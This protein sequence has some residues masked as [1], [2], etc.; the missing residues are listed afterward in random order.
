M[1]SV[2]A[3]VQAVYLVPTSRPPADPI[4]VV[5]EYASRLLVAS[6]PLL[7]GEM[8]DRS[9]LRVRVDPAESTRLPPPGVLESFGVSADEAAAVEAASHVVTVRAL[10]RPSWP[11]ANEWVARV[12]A[13][14]I[15][16]HVGCHVIDARLPMLVSPTVAAEALPDQR[17]LFAASRWLLVSQQARTDG[18]WCYTIGLSRFGLPELQTPAV[19]PQLARA[20]TEMLTGLANALVKWWVRLVNVADPPPFVDLP[21]MFSFTNWDMAEAYRSPRPAERKSVSVRLLL[22]PGQ[23]NNTDT[24][25]TVSPP[26]DYGAPAG[27][28]LAEVCA[29]LLGVTKRSAFRPVIQSNQMA[30]AIE[31]A[32]ATLPSARQRF[33]NGELR[34]GTQLVVKSRVIT[35]GTDEYLWAFVTSW[36][37]PSVIRATSSANSPGD[38]AIKVG[39]PLTIPVDDVVD[40]GAWRDGHGIIE[41]GWTNAAS[42]E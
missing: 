30:E 17:C 19:P 3:R 34:Q 21:S 40:W 39:V 8:I 25:L 35:S 38:P 31:T 2:P 11:P 15:G 41:G 33:L 28:F 7:V 9:L 32:R 36:T 18:F 12:A 4:A 20:W 22:D 6:L 16:Q 10:Y 1:L 23:P 29:E 13:I 37:N 24:F 26:V 42:A 14:A 5:R 27:R